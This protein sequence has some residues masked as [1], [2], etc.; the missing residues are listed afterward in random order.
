MVTLST[1]A[2]LQL[3]SLYSNRFLFSNYI[4]RDRNSSYL[5]HC[6]RE[7]FEVQNQKELHYYIRIKVYIPINTIT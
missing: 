6:Y 4:V 5:K 1:K 7:Q 2:L 3:S